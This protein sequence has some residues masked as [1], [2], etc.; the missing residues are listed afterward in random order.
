MIKM[1]KINCD[2]CKKEMGC[3]YSH[4]A[5]PFEDLVHICS[6]C[7]TEISDQVNSA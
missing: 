3:I 6:K 2:R 7:V 1:L 4:G 5:L